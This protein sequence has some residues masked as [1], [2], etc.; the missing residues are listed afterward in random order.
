MYLNCSVCAPHLL[1]VFPP[2]ALVYTSK[3][4]PP[5]SP[6][7]GGGGGGGGGGVRLPGNLRHL[8]DREQDGLGV[9]EQPP[10]GQA[11]QQQD[12]NAALQ[13][14]TDARQVL[15]AERLGG[16][17]DAVRQ[18]KTKPELFSIVAVV[19]FVVVLFYFGSSFKPGPLEC[20]MRGTDRIQSLWWKCL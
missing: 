20:R 16:G 8:A 4:Y 11:E 18:N 3:C 19:D 6:Q 17:G 13:D 5:P 12:Q 15:A 14:H 1:K 9:E 2:E 10:A 7:R